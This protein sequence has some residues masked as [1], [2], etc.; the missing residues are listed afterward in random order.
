MKKGRLTQSLVQQK[1]VYSHCLL[2]DKLTS[3]KYKALNP[4]FNY[5]TQNFRTSQTSKR[6]RKV[7]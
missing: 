6:N 4:V 7:N 3:I 5:L 1:K 2:I